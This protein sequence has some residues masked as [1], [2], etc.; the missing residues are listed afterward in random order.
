[1]EREMSTPNRQT[2]SLQPPISNIQILNPQTPPPTPNPQP[3]IPKPWIPIWTYWAG[4]APVLFWDFL[5]SSISL[6][7]FGT[8]LELEIH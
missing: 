7:G 3:Y 8:K 4:L 2:P 5:S 6:V 1:M